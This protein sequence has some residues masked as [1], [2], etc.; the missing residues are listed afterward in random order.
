M[1][2]WVFLLLGPATLLGQSMRTPAG[3]YARE[4][5]NYEEF[6]DY[7]EVV[8]AASLAPVR[9]PRAGDTIALAAFF[10]RTR[11]IDNIQLR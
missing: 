5:A 6:D 10:G 3:Q 11:L 8:D 1:R 7:I 4:A 9:N 2:F